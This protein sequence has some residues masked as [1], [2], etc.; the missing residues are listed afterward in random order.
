MQLFFSQ[1]KPKNAPKD[2]IVNLRDTL[3]MLE[4]RENHLQSKI[5]AEIKTARSHAT[6]NKRAALMALK[7]KK[8]Y[9]TQMEKLSGAKFTIETQV[10]AIESANVNLETIKAME[11]VDDTMDSIREQMDLSDEIS[12]AISGPML[13][14][15]LD[16]VKLEAEL[17]EL[18]QENLDKQLLEVEL[19]LAAPSV[20]AKKLENLSI[21]MLTYSL[22]GSANYGLC[23]GE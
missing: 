13:G 18:E 14:I 5:D 1:K 9:E 17:E 16:D 2:A 22:S 4:K 10:M 23:L 8:Q 12:N 15:P 7:R 6:T 3:Q 20:P 11:T 21:I 19:P